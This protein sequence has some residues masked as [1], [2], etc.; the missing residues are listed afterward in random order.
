M[1]E[2]GRKV[3]GD[4]VRVGGGGGGAEWEGVIWVCFNLSLLGLQQMTRVLLHTEIK[5]VE[6]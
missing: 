3:E 4:G 5:R 6:K 2:R 1:L